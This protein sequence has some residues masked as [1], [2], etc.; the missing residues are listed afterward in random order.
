ME[1]QGGVN[2]CS[3]YFFSAAL[4][5]FWPAFGGS[6]GSSFFRLNG[7]RL[8]V[9]IVLCFFAMLQASTI[10]SKGEPL[11]RNDQ[12][13]LWINTYIHTIFRGMNIHK[14]QLFWCELQGDRVL[15]HPQVEPQFLLMSS[16]QGVGWFWI[17]YSPFHQF[18]D[19]KEHKAT[20]LM[21]V[22]GSSLISTGIS[23]RK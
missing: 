2:S 3:T 6:L 15:T 16:G 11:R 4:W 9:L 5:P 17:L 1:S 12:S 14:S 10:L 20:S 13:W 22:R 7:F 8:V 18:L 21:L 19:C 23:S